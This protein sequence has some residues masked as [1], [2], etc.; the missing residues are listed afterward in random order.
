[1]E[2]G[3]TIECRIDGNAYG[4]DGIARVD[5]MVVF[6][7][8]AFRGETVKA[9]IRQVKKRFAKAD[10]AELVEPSVEIP[11]LSRYAQVP[12]MVYAPIPPEC[13]LALKSAQL[14]NFLSKLD[15]EACII[16]EPVVCGDGLGYRNKVTYHVDGGKVGY[17]EE[18][19]HDVVEIEYDPL[20]CDPINA[21]LS[22]ARRAAVVPNS[23]HPVSRSRSAASRSDDVLTIRHTDR[24]GVHYWRGSAPRDLMLHE[25]T[26]GLVFEVPAGGFYQVNPAVG[27]KLVEEVVAAYLEDPGDLLDLYCGVGV[28][29]IACLKA[30]V[31]RLERAGASKFPRLVGVESGRDSVA[32]AKRNAAAAGVA[33]N[34]FCERVGASLGRMRVAPGHT[35]IVDP[36]RGGLEPNVAPW[37]AKCGAARILYVSCDPATLTRDLEGLRAGYRITRVRLFQMFPRTARFETLVRLE[38]KDR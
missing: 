17:R 28:F 12:G 3:E 29:G 31:A 2:V 32:A 21:A 16:D 30:A 18:G 8:G 19:S 6:V 38:R 33:A 7:K 4:G 15:G 20:A 37:L 11:R 27:E 34:F 9:R 24:D 22:A 35:V 1:M 25:D 10:F 5:G 23:R 26:A 13:E 36:P 14:E